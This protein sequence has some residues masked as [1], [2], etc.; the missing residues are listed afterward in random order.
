MKIMFF[1]H[2]VPHF[3]QKLINSMFEVFN[4]SRQAKKIV[5]DN[6]L[7]TKVPMFEACSFKLIYSRFQRV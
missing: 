2:K 7:F 6:Q 5:A 1:A 4:H 3:Y